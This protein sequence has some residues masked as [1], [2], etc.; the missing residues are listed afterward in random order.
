MRSPRPPRG[1]RSSGRHY[2]RTVATAGETTPT[3]SRSQRTRA[4]R[5][6]RPVHQRARSHRN[7]SA[8]PTAFSRSPWPGITA[9]LRTPPD[10]TQ[11]APTSILMP[12]HHATGRDPRWA[13]ILSEHDRV[14]HIGAIEFDRSGDASRLPVPRQRCRPYCADM[15]AVAGNGE[16]RPRTKVRTTS[17]EQRNRWKSAQDARLVGEAVLTRILLRVSALPAEL[18][19]PGAPGSVAPA[20]TYPSGQFSRTSADARPPE[21]RWVRRLDAS[22]RH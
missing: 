7:G 8:C 15:R 9:T 16:S 1:T 5:R 21:A 4:S 20:E 17:I 22:A 12:V 6:G 13:P 19:R 18:R 11:P 3:D 10:S 14:S 2:Q